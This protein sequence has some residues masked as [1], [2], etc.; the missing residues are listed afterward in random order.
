M[1]KEELVT[2]STDAGKFAGLT[3]D[4]H[5]ASQGQGA[6]PS[7]VLLERPLHGIPGSK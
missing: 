3:L 2:V 1:P 4:A 7:T 6:D 5:K